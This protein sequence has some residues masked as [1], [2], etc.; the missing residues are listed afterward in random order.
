MEIYPGENG[1]G[2]RLNGEELPVRTVEPDVLLVRMP[3]S[4][5]DLILCAD[6]AGRVWGGRF[7]GR[8]IPRET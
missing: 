4:D 2:L 5:L 1:V 3:L 7:R 8:I 6:R